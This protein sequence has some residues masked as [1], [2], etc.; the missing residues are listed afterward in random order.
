M[1]VWKGK[2]FKM[3]GSH[4]R[5]YGDHVQGTESVTPLEGGAGAQ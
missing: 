3:C 1:V 5:E 2:Q 4:A